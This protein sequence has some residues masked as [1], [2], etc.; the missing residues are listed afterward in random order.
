MSGYGNQE[1]E[2]EEEWDDEPGLVP[3]IDTRID[4]GGKAEPIPNDLRENPISRSVG[5]RQAEAFGPVLSGCGRRLLAKLIDSTVVGVLVIAAAIWWTGRFS[6]EAKWLWTFL[7]MLFAMTGSWIVW[8]LYHTLLRSD[9]IGKRLMGLRV[10]DE[11]AR[12]VGLGRSAGRALAEMISVATLGIGYLFA[13]VD[14]HRRSL[15]DH[16]CGTRVVLG[17]SLPGRLAGGALTRA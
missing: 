15:H 9:T 8:L 3:W 5:E 12:P 14:P 10:V 2:E 4:L 17:Q 16:L 11:R 6:G 7:S 1:P 13:V